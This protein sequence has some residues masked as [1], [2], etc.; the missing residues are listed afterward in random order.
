MPELQLIRFRGGVA[1]A[2]LDYGRENSRKV[3][4]IKIFAMSKLEGR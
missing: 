2:N 3:N 4:I 1:A